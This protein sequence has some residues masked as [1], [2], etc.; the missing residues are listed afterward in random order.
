MLNG[1]YY[2]H[3]GLR[4]LVVLSAVIALGFMLFSLFTNREQDRATRMV[5]VTFSSLIGLQ[6]VI[7]MIYYIVLGGALSEAGFED[8]YNLRNSAVHA[9]VMTIVLL[10]AHLYL[11]FRRRAGTRNY[12]IVS[13]VVVASTL[14]LIFVG[15]S[16][17]LGDF[18]ARWSFSGNFPPPV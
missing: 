18:A 4:W 12:Y 16:M 14:V 8:A 17:L 1:L 5:M 13:T 9:A 15:V 3:T 2:A 10:V 6:W 11:P 7:G